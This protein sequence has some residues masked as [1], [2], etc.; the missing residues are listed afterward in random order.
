MPLLFSVLLCAHQTGCSGRKRDTKLWAAIQL[1]LTPGLSLN[2]NR[3][4]FSFASPLPILN[5]S[6]SCL[7]SFCNSCRCFPH[8]FQCQNLYFAPNLNNISPLQ[9]SHPDFLLLPDPPCEFISVTICRAARPQRVAALLSPCLLKPLSNM[10]IF[11]RSSAQSTNVL[12]QGLAALRGEDMDSLQVLVCALCTCVS[13]PCESTNLRMSLLVWMAWCD[14]QRDLLH[15]PQPHHPPAAKPRSYNSTVTSKA[16]VTFLLQSHLSIM[17]QHRITRTPGSVL[18]EHS[19][20]IL[21]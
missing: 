13:M 15:P 16:P 3:L 7:F 14:L 18:I 5:H 1:I 19:E 21:E 17:L 4:L 2:W 10:S 9:L 6:L 20:L 12:L 11:V 8:A